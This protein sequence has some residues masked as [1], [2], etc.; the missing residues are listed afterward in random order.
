MAIT[1]KEIRVQGLGVPRY[2]SS[3]A[4]LKL[5]LRPGSESREPSVIIRAQRT[6]GQPIEPGLFETEDF[7]VEVQ[8][9][10]MSVVFTFVGE[11]V[12]AV[13]TAVAATGD[14]KEIG[15]HL[16]PFMEYVTNLSE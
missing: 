9:L 10:L 14:L 16:M 6:W 12:R 13:A 11:K 15:E 5:I 3:A 7:V 4:G 8:R 2:T 1:I